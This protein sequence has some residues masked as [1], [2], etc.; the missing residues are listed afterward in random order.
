MTREEVLRFAN[1]LLATCG[2]SVQT[3]ESIVAAAYDVGLKDGRN[4]LASERD[5]QTADLVDR[6]SAAL[7]EKLLRSQRKYGY[8]DGWKHSDWVLAG[9]CNDALIAHV[10]KGDPLDVAAYCAFL[11]HHGA[12]TRKEG[13]SPSVATSLKADLQGSGPES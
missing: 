1:A 8:T 6:F 10:E 13:S 11:W 12:S 7:K 5:P 4:S 9:E 2:A 3:A